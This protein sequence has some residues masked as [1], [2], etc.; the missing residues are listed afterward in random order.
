MGK[1]KKNP[2]YLPI[3]ALG[4]YDRCLRRVVDLAPVLDRFFVE[5]LV[6]AEDE[7]VRK[8]R[9]AL[10]SAIGKS[11]SRTARLSEVVVDKGEPKKG[12]G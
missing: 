2:V 1:R 6:M 7:T 10:L 5:V 4:D 3:K 11:F 8:N 12:E 9:L